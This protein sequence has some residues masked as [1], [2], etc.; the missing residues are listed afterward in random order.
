[1][2]RLDHAE[3][4][5][6]LLLPRLHGFIQQLLPCKTGSNLSLFHSPRMTC[7]EESRDACAQHFSAA[8]T[9]YM[10]FK[11]HKSLAEQFLP[12]LLHR[13]ADQ[14]LGEGGEDEFQDELCD[15][16]MVSSYWFHYFSNQVLPS[17][18]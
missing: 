2:M 3:N 13:L 4:I 15:T 16:V 12:S 7:A 6:V 10:R 11:S 1:M 17:L 5:R 8:C 18:S 9:Q 14:V